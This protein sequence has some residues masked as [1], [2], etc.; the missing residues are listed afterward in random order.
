MEFDPRE[1]Y[2]T[3]VLYGFTVVIVVGAVIGAFTLS[4]VSGVVTDERTETVASEAT[5]QANTVSLLVS[6]VE[7]TATRLAD[8]TTRV[9]GSYVVE[10]V[11]TQKLEELYRSRALS[12]QIGAVHLVN[13]SAE[14]FVVSTAAYNSGNS[15]DPLGYQV[16]DDLGAGKTAFTVSQAGSTPW[17]VFAGT[18]SGDTL[19]VEVPLAY[20]QSK[21]ASV[22]DESQTRIVD[23]D[24]MVVFD[25]NNLSAVGTQHTPGDGVGSGVVRASID[26]E[27]GSVV[28]SAAESPTGEQTAAGYDRMAATGWAVVTYAETDELFAA[29]GTLQRNLLLLLGAIAVLLLGMGLVVERPALRDL[30]RLQSD[31]QRLQAGDLD[32]AVERQRRDEIGDL[33]QG[34]ETMRGNLRDQIAEAEAATESAREARREAE[35]LS[36]HLESKAETYRETLQRLADGDFT[37]RVDAESRHEGMQAVGETLNSVVAELETT[38]GEVQTFADQVADSMQELSASADEIEQATSDV[39]QTVQEISA[40]TDDQRDRL[41]TVTAEMNNLSATVEEVASTSEAVARDADAAAERG[42]EGRSAAEDAAAALDQ[43]EAEME[44]AVGEVETLVD[45][46]EEIE[47]FADVIGDVAEQT[48]ML[49]LNANIEAARADVDGAG[50]AVVADE[51]KSLAEETSDRAD[52]ITAAI[53]DVQRQTSATADRIR[54]AR[55]RL[56]ESSETVETA[57]DALIEIDEI[58]ERTNE[59]IQDINRATDDQASTTEEVAATVESVSELA[60]QNATDAGEVSA[61]AEQQTATVSEVSRTAETLAGQA[62]TLSDTLTQFTVNP[63]DDREGGET[64]RDAGIDSSDAGSDSPVQ[65]R[66]G[67]DD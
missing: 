23:G 47:T 2:R 16:P 49:A 61:A 29:A 64:D 66:S 48:N 54:T 3:K 5:V 28:L 12:L 55:G 60:E 6:N 53:D 58:V 39:A 62:A 46:V 32:S 30:T 19:V 36:E 37:A 33:A 34:L 11:Q 44:S 57:I 59:G 45:Q 14:E 15:T 63:D 50:F 17:V 27:T 38:L 41:Q 40:G 42:Q 56:G 43:I 20:V 4:G 35:E 31:V 7:S 8:T 24:G 13:T 65:T 22:L 10:Q 18:E 67:A 1:S 21:T 25:G 9:R 51:V 26:G 52:D